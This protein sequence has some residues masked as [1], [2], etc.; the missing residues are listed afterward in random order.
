MANALL[1]N[2][3]RLEDY[4]IVLTLSGDFDMLA[5]VLSDNL[6]YGH[7]TGSLDT[8]AS[9]LKLLREGT[10]EYV[11]IVSELDVA[12]RLASGIVLVSGML[13]TQVKVLGQLKELSG[14]YM[15]VWRQDG[16]QWKLEAL[17]GSNRNSS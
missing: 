3:Q 2:M 15:A 7:S 5:D 6:V 4:R 11:S 17:Q 8:K 10:V 14:R 1:A 16:D 9:M 12:S 13:T